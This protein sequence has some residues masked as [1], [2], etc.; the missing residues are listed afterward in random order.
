[1]L[2]DRNA[3]EFFKALINVWSGIAQSEQRFAK[4]WM[5]RESNPGKGEI[6]LIRPDRPWGPPNLLYNH[7]WVIPVGKVAGA[8]P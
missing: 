3:D 1:M 2:N 6:F 8:W 7:Y 5:V 4:A